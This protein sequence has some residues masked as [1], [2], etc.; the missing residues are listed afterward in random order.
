MEITPTSDLNADIEASI[1]KLKNYFK[2][3]GMPTSLKELN[4]TEEAFETLAENAMF[5]GKRILNDIVPIDYEKALEI[6]KL[7]S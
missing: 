7:A 2:S 3:I 4:I 5:K 6:Y 1:D